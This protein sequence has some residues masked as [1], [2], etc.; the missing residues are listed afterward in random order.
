MFS[1]HETVRIVSA[2]HLRPRPLLYGDSHHSH[3]HNYYTCLRKTCHLCFFYDKRTC[4]LL[5]VFSRLLHLGLASPCA[6]E[7][8]LTGSQSVQVQLI[9]SAPFSN[10]T[11]EDSVD[12]Y[13]K[14]QPNGDIKSTRYILAAKLENTLLT[15]RSNNKNFLLLPSTT[16]RTQKNSIAK[17]RP[18][19][20]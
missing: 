9:C 11:S 18:R 17:H 2:T 6:S 16:T 19:W 15:P 7:I 1:H 20:K 3:Y 12:L 5:V 8:A 14:H 10:Q 13:K 4:L